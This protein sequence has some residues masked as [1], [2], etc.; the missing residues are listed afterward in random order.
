[1]GLRP[2]PLPSGGRLTHGYS[3]GPSSPR[4]KGSSPGS[5]APGQSLCPPPAQLCSETGTPSSMGAWPEATSGVGAVTSHPQ[6]GTHEPRH[7][8]PGAEARLC[9][10]L[11]QPLACSL[12]GPGAWQGCH[13]SPDLSQELGVAKA[14]PC[15]GTRGAAETQNRGP[16]E[17]G[18]LP[19]PRYAAEGPGKSSLVGATGH[20]GLRPLR[21]Q[22]LSRGR[23]VCGHFPDSSVPGGG[24]WGLPAC[25][26]SP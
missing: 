3:L 10:L 20:G 26:E 9:A 25:G 18:G 17:Q 19:A 11:Q 13:V 8:L 4:G 21:S 1:M 23:P 15:P 7:G 5:P 2:E 14:L 12:A 16:P 22:T 6:T 24:P